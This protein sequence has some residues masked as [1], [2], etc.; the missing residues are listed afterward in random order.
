MSR[1][2]HASTEALNIIR[3][4]ECDA[5]D[6]LA[7]SRFQALWNEI[8]RLQ[9]RLERST[10]K[11]LEIDEQLVEAQSELGRR[12]KALE[13]IGELLFAFGPEDAPTKTIGGIVR[14]SLSE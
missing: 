6:N 8:E 13:E 7:T 2:P 9:S 4:N 10:R 11:C 12:T 3:S 14:E 5:Q 1:Y